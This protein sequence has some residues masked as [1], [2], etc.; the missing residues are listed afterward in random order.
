MKPAL[1]FLYAFALLAIAPVLMQAQTLRITLPKHSYTTPVQRLNQEG[2]KAVNK[3]DLKKAE[4]LFYK[5]YLLDPDNP[6]TLSNLGY[7]SE[8]HGNVQAALRFYKLAATH[9]TDTTIAHSSVSSLKG[10]PLTT[11]T[12][13]FA[14][15]DL[16]VNYGNIEAMGLLQ[17]GRSAEAENVLRDTLRLNPHSAFTLNNLGYTLEA[18]GDLNSAYKYYTEAASQHSSE[19]IVVAPDPRWRGKAISEI[20]E[21]NADA[22]TKRIETEDSRAAQVARLNLQGVSALNHNDRQKAE[23]D[24]EKAYQLDPNDAFTLN[25]MGYVSE[26]KG[27]EET[28]N[29]FYQQA[30]QAPGANLPATITSRRVLQGRS[31]SNV[32]QSNTS[33]AQANLE[34]E[35]AILRRQT[36][37][38]VLRRRNNQPVMTPQATPQTTPASPAQTPSNPPPNQ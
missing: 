28:A 38:I 27:D 34:A 22:V 6:F 15:G 26:L 7:I 31:L 12:E 8:V 1:R 25:N 2:V 32:A 37:P 14:K 29:D 21:N 13:N 36:G 33:T 18:E 3:H 35:Q 19:K 17:Q 10:K 4:R 20:A 16:R 30:Q 9:E 23:Q 24:F 5:A 11:I